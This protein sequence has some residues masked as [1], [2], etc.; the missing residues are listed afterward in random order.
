MDS[1][2]SVNKSTMR[3]RWLGWKVVAG[4]L[5][6]S[7]MNRTSI[8]SRAKVGSIHT[9]IAE[10]R[11]ALEVVL[12]SWTTEASS[13][14]KVN[15]ATKAALPC[16]S[17]WFDSLASNCCSKSQVPF[18]TF[19]IAVLRRVWR[20]FQRCSSAL[21]FLQPTTAD[22][23]TQRTSWR[24]I[25]VPITIQSRTVFVFIYRNENESV[26]NYARWQVLNLVHWDKKLVP[27]WAVPKEVTSDDAND[28]VKQLQWGVV[29]LFRSFTAQWCF[30][31]RWGKNSRGRW[32]QRKN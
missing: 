5:P 26:Q 32:N 22:P 4:F 19:S 18:V 1:V 16:T 3:N 17:S 28:W 14:S 27:G 30:Y 21:Q 8:E 13:L 23:S 29:H 2:T 15:V 10:W 7:S 12:S 9:L 24:W 11:T 6:W 31:P 20:S 25:C